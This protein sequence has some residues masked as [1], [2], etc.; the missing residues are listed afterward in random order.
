MVGLP[1]ATVNA[2]VVGV[3]VGTVDV[4]DAWSSLSPA[5]RGSPGGGG[6]MVRPFAGR[7]WAWAV[8]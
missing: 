6:T 4:G 2:R 1:A 8:P 7:V 3:G 5:M